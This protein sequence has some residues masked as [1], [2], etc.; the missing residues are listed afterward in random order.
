MSRIAAVIYTCL[1]IISLSFAG[2]SFADD[3]DRGYR[4]YFRGRGPSIADIVINTDGLDTLEAALAANDLV[5]LFDG[6]K[7]FTVFA[8][9]NEAFAELG[10]DE[11]SDL[12]GLA[13]V[14]GYHASKGDL[15]LEE[16]VT[17]GEL[18]MLLSGTT[19]TGVSS[20][21]A[22]IKGNSNP[23]A[24]VIVVEGLDARNGVVYV[25]DTVLLP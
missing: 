19:M 14:L 11:N 23:A 24:A 10:L 7:R 3:D 9:T 4:D 8:P 15:S 13:D 16:V 6:R 18:Q 12:S 5:G 2:V 22:F 25:I 1:L 21:G 17:A 20:D